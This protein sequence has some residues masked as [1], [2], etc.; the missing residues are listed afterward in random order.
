MKRWAWILLLFL[1][2]ASFAQSTLVSG[3][4][5]D[6]AS[7]PFANGTY[8]IDFYPNGTSGPYVWNGSP[9]TLSSTVF[10]GNLNVSGAFSGV[11]VPSNDKI[12]PTGSQWRFTVCSLATS[13][14]FS[15]TLPVTG[16]ALDVSALVNPPTIVVSAE[17]FTHLSAYQDSELTGAKLG[18]SYF[19]L[20]DGTI[21]LCT[22][23]QCTWVSIG[24]GTGGV[25]G[26]GTVNTV[27]KF[28]GVTTVCNSTGTDDGVNPTAWPSGLTTTLNGGDWYQMPNSSFGTGLQLAACQSSSAYAA[29]TCPLGATGSVIGFVGG[30]FSSGAPGTTGNVNLCWG[31]KCSALFD[32]QTTPG[33]YGILSTSVA[34]E[35]HDTG[36]TIPTAGFENFLI[37]SANG[38]AGT[39]ANIKLLTP[40]QIANNAGTSTGTLTAPFIPVATGS[41]TLGNSTCKDDGTNPTRCPNGMDTA[42]SGVLIERT[43]D[44][45]GVVAN[46]LAC[47]SSISLAVICPAGATTTVLGAAQ[48]TV[49][50]GN[51][52][53][54]FWGGLVQIVAATSFTAGHWLIPSAT[55]IGEVDD[56]GS[57]TP[58]VSITQAFRVENSGSANALAT[59]DL[60]A[61]DTLQSGSGSGGNVTENFTGV[62]ELLVNGGPTATGT[63][64]I[65][66]K[67]G[68]PSGEAW[69][70]PPS[71]AFANIPHHSSS[72]C[73]TATSCTVTLQVGGSTDGIVL[74]ANPD[75]APGAVTITDSFGNT[76]P[77]VGS[78]AWVVCSS[79]GSGS[80]V[81]HLSSANS[82]GW[83]MSAADI[84][85]NATSSCVDTAVTNGG[86]STSITSAGSVSQSSELIFGYFNNIGS[87]GTGI[88]VYQAGAGYTQVEQVNCPTP[89]CARIA[90]ILEVNNQNTSLSGTQ[91]ATTNRTGGLTDGSEIFAIKLSTPNANGPLSTNFITWP[92]LPVAT[93]TPVNG[94]CLDVLVQ[95]NG[96]VFGDSGAPCA[97][98]YV[99]GSTSATAPSTL[100][101][102]DT[103]VT[104]TPASVGQAVLITPQTSPGTNVSWSG[105]VSAANQVDIR[106]CTLVA[107]TPSAVTYQIRVFK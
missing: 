53:E 74:T 47:R 54:I 5:R 57:S 37:D 10:T 96:N 36:L 59:I 34:G 49:S 61:L 7:Q 46:K 83:I 40:D 39:A 67:S 22:A 90:Q 42:A 95:T 31:P 8:R 71:N 21:H 4:I 12:T 101:C 45:G 60:L 66:T 26:T 84:I 28:C 27:T 98:A 3:T 6:A 94:D 20:S 73:A 77:T 56:T 62:P 23:P 103:T 89:S 65:M 106:L 104:F 30:S 13:P 2:P 81:I 85:G 68:Q 91:T 44:T 32:N 17:L 82:V 15:V 78:F 9:F 11:S 35:L 100:G 76:F 75:G 102:N 52:V 87:L 79:L 41:T 86:T 25:G 58:P 63:N 72:A 50:S 105:F 88:A 51:T 18:T 55:V 14:C 24:V 48:S 92:Y 29:M 99:S 43:V 70:T 38:G 93:Q 16:T 107:F 64:F 80:D 1:A 19:N 97:P 69:L 33:H